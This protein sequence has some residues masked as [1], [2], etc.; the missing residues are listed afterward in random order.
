MAVEGQTDLDLDD[1]EVK[2][3]NG[4]EPN[5]TGEE[6]TKVEQKKCI[7]L[8][9]FCYACTHPCLTKYNPLPEDASLSQRFKYG[10]MCPPHGNLAKWTMFVFMFFVAW[11]VMI[12]MT[13][14]G[15]MPGGN[16]FSL[17]VMFFT[18]VFGGY[19][20]VFLRLPP[21]LGK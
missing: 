1:I 14:A 21:L 12:S 10:F 9:A 11:A 6:E 18:C 20:I 3:P 7:A 16:F 15:G 19:F 17:T 4:T 8:R 2:Q 13:G 5:E